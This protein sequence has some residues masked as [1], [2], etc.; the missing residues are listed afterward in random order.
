[1]PYL[2]VDGMSLVHRSR[3]AFREMTNSKGEI[4]GH[5]YGFLVTLQSQKRKHPEC[6]IVV[7]WDSRPQRRINVYADYKANRN[8]TDFGDGIRDI[9]TVLSSLNITQA[10][11]EGEEADDVI[12]AL[13]R[14]Y[15]NEGSFVYI[16]AR[17]K[18]LLQL[19][20][21]GKVV[22]LWPNNGSNPETPFDE[23]KVRDKFGVD[24]K[25]LK[26][27][28]VFRGDDQD[29]IPGIP[30]LRSKTI[31]R[32]VNKYHTPKSIYA[33]L[34]A[35]DLTDFERQSFDQFEAQSRINEELVSLRDDFDPD[36]IKGG[37]DPETIESLL[38]KYSIKKIRAQHLVEVFAEEGSFHMRTSPA[39]K[40]FSLFGAEG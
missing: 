30:H 35:E 29:N 38:Q 4:S 39:V 24:S 2:I 25:G 23:E 14:K 26:S 11:K 36:L 9:K 17:D 20:Q 7:A 22:V 18:D 3:W 21:D 8:H 27:Y 13:C 19:V 37:S 6:K 16:Y 40:E 28:L 10:Q 33:S 15:V 32:L 1:M 5:F 34:D 12:A 31:V